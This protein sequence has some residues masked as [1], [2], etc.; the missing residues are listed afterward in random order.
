[1]LTGMALLT[2]HRGTCLRKRVGCVIAREGRVLTL[3]YNGAPKGLPHCLDHGCII[4][5]DGGCTRA[6]HAEANA[7]AFAARHGIKLDGATLYV[8][9]SPCKNCASLIINAGIQRVVFAER[10]RDET[11]LQKL[12]EAGVDIDEKPTLPEL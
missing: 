3:G 10:Y 11:G 12:V 9:T 2:A 8:T 5:P 1:M 4:G 6:A 7:I